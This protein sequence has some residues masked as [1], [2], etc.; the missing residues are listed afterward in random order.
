MADAPLTGEIAIQGLA[1]VMAGLGKYQSEI[2]TR[3]RDRLIAAANQDASFAVFI[4]RE[5]GLYS[6]G[7][8]IDRIKAGWRSNY[9]FITDT[10]RRISPA[11]PAGFNYPAVYEYAGSTTRANQWGK[12][13][14]IRNRSITGVR[15]IAQYGLGEGR[16]GPR[17]FLWPA[18]V[19]GE[20]QLLLSV[21]QALAQLAAD[22]GLAAA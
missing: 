11:Y 3:L 9:A 4:A 13:F 20:P 21:E 10:A 22:C 19:E 12:G 5:K 2:R 14:Q 7:E 15:L 17:A 18:A 8:L 1:E 6:S 16:V